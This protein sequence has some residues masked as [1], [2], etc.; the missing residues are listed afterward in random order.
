MVTI[1]FLHSTKLL[2]HYTYTFFQ[3]LLP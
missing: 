3:D 2:P 1:L